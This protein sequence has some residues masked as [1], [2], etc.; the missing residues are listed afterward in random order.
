MPQRRMIF[1]TDD[2][3]H[4]PITVPSSLQRC[5]FLQQSFMDKLEAT[6]LKTYVGKVNMDRN[7]PEFLCET[8]PRL[9]LWQRGVD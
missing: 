4:S 3:K 9:P 7:S 2:L 5:T 8:P 6:G 1:F